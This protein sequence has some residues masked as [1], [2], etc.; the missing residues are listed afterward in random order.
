ML[1]FDLNKTNTISDPLLLDKNQSIQVKLV[2][3][4]FMAKDFTTYNCEVI[5]SRLCKACLHVFCVQLAVPL[6]QC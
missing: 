5:E 4:D 1:F 6:L 2:G 3:I